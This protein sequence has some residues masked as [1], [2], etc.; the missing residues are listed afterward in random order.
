[1]VLSKVAARNQQLLKIFESFPFS[2]LACLYIFLLRSHGDIELNAR[3]NK[4]KENNLSICHWNL[5]CA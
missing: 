3:P 1:M 2:L 4:S 5:S